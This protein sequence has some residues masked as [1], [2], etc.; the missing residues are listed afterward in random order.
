LAEPLMHHGGA[1]M[2]VSFYGAETVVEHY[3]LMRPVKAALGKRLAVAAL[4]GG[5]RLVRVW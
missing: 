2:T 4:C 5:G 3:N 1:L